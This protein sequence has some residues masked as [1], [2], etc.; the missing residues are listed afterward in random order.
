MPAN[1]KTNGRASWLG[2]EHV[3]IRSEAFFSLTSHETRLLVAMA[4]KYNGHNNSQIPYSYEEAV[5][6]LHCS[7]S[8]AKRA[9]AG[10][11]KKGLIE[12][13]ELGSFRIKNG[14]RKGAATLWR[15]KFYPDRTGRKDGPP[16]H[17]DLNKP[18]RGISA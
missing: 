13:T 16:G 3:L 15:L 14:E 12:P 10:L 2:F 9:F 17:G 5:M 7:Y 4:D 18:S 11:K 6:W 1:G 8:T